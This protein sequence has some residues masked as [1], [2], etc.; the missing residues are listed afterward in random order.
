MTFTTPFQLYAD[1][2]NLETLLHLQAI[3]QGG[4]YETSISGNFI[5]TKTEMVQ[6][7]KILIEWLSKPTP[8]DASAISK[9]MSIRDSANE[10]IFQEG[11]LNYLQ[12]FH[13][14]GE[15]WTVTDRIIIFEGQ[16]MVQ[17][18]GSLLAVEIITIW[19]Y[20]LLQPT[21]IFQKTANFLQVRRFYNQQGQRINDI[22]YRLDSEP[23]VNFEATSW[24]DLLKIL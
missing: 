5:A 12:R 6:G 16:P 7:V 23:I 2:A 8:Y 20:Y 15:I 3:W 10:N 4:G 11:F 14:I 17:L 9:L 24:Q 21:S 1:S 22:I 19:M 13:F 18:R